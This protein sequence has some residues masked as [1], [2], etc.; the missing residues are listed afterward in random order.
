MESKDTITKAEKQRKSIA[1]T[2]SNKLDKLRNDFFIQHFFDYMPK[3]I[4]L[5][6]IKYNKAL[7]KR[8]EININ[9]YK[10]FSEK[11]S[12]IEIEIIPK[13]NKY[14]EFIIIKKED[15]NHYHIY[16]NDNK[17]K[18]IK[19]TSINKND[20]V[21]KINVIIDYQ[22]T[23]LNELFNYCKCIESINFKQFYRNNITN[24][25]AMF[26]GC[27]SLKELNL[28]NFNTNNVND[29]SGLFY[30]CSSLKE[31]NLNNFNTN[32]VTNMRYMFSGC[33]SLK[34]LNLN[35]FNTNNVTNMRSMFSWCYH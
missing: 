31:L 21:S 4:S 14:G 9:H 20:N 29:M 23:S 16:F 33:S 13:K 26:N 27:T 22:V 28:N 18:K 5:K 30:Q 32:N 34:E 15:I 35:N 11:F 3:R 2:S 24:M 6:A 8:I 10:D 1:T 19:K 12:S 7:Q 25:S 17:R